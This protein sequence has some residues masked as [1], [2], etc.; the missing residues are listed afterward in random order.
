MQSLTIQL[1]DPRHHANMAC[2]SV[3]AVRP[4]GSTVVSSPI[5]PTGN[6]ISGALGKCTAARLATSASSAASSSST[7]SSS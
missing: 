1:H 2:L 4:A 6:C 5:R 3:C 7:S